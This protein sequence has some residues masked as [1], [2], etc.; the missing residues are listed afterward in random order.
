MRAAV[1]VVCDCDVVKRAQIAWPIRHVDEAIEKS[2]RCSAK[3]EL[4]GL[5]QDRCCSATSGCRL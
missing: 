2:V 1:D 3:V 5:I 4:V